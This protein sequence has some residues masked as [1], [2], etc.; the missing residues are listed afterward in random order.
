MPNWKVIITDGLS[1]KGKT[2][3]SADA[4]VNDCSG[5]SAEELLETIRDCNALIVRGRTKVTDSSPGSSPK[6]EGRGTSRC[7]GR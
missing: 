2:I 4:E 1:Q 7:G 3:L 6:Y 5:I